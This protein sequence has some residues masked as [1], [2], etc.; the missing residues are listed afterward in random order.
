MGVFS[1]QNSVR[2]LSSAVPFRELF[3]RTGARLLHFFVVLIFRGRTLR[4]GPA[5]PD[6]LPSRARQWYSLPSDS[7]STGK[8]DGRSRA[9]GDIFTGSSTVR[10]LNHQQCAVAKVLERGRWIKGIHRLMSGGCHTPVE[11]ILVLVR[12]IGEYTDVCAIGVH[13]ARPVTTLS[14]ETKAAEQ[15][16][17]PTG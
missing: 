10:L 12:K 11:V 7:Q 1:S 16:M 15:D 3:M 6:R 5:P 13:Q 8:H 4:Q 2:G 9:V 14:V 17:F